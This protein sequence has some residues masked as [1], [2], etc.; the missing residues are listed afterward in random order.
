MIMR[1][2]FACGWYLTLTVL[3]LTDKRLW[4]A[5]APY[6]VVA[7]VAFAIGKWI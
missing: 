6:I 1:F 4:K 7:A 3:H 5:V 2:F